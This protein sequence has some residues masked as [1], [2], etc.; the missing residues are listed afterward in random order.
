[1]VSER[2]VGAALCSRCPRFEVGSDFEARVEFLEEALG[3]SFA[4]FKPAVGS[5]VARSA[6]RA[7]VASSTVIPQ[8]G[9]LVTDFDC[10]MV[11][12]LSCLLLLVVVTVF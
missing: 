5:Q 1:M 7:G 9:S 11:M 2:D 3:Y 8:M 4:G 10:L 12:F 6:W